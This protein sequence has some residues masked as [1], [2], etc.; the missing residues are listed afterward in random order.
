MERYVQESSIEE[1]DRKWRMN[2]ADTCWSIYID[3]V[4]W[5]NV[6]KMYPRNIDVLTDLALAHSYRKVHMCN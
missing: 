2:K 5:K 6:V 1:N 4:S 3:E